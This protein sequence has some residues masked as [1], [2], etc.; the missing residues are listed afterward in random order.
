VVEYAPADQ[1]GGYG[2]WQWATVT[3]ELAAGIATAALFSATLDG[4]ALRAWGWRLA[5]LL[6]LPLG[7]VGLWIRLRID[8]TPAFRAV[9][10]LDAAARTP[11]AE[12]LR[13]SRRSVLV[14]FGIVAAVTATFN[15]TFVFLPSHLATTGRAPW[16]RRWRPR[17]SASWWP[18]LPRR[19]P[20]GSLTGWV[21]GRRCSPVV[22]PS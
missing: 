10:R 5:F 15:I 2:G 11:L 13:T 1:R 20:A 22:S 19:S 6:A 9:Q 4:P 17:W 21:A 12:T 14:G 7:L 8:E 18:P 16:P 3:L